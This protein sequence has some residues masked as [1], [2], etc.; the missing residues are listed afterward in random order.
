MKPRALRG[1]RL[2]LPKKTGGAH[3]SKKRRGLE[4]ERMNVMRAE[5]TNALA[6]YY[7]V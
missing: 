5:F 6:R 2:P 7:G 3:R 1:V 4:R